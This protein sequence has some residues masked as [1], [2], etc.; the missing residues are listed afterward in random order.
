MGGEGIKMSTEVRD[1]YTQ[2]LREEYKGLGYKPLDAINALWHDYAETNNFAEYRA[3]VGAG[4]F[5][6][7]EAV[8]E[9]AKELGAEMQ[10]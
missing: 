1:S 4:Y 8:V 6:M 5:E 2:V 3:E 9:L 7:L 10:A